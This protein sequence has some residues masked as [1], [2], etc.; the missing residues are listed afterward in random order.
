LVGSHGRAE[1]VGIKLG[2]HPWCFSANEQ[3]LESRVFSFMELLSRVEHQHPVVPLAALEHAGKYKHSTG[4][5]RRLPAP[6]WTGPFIVFLFF[7]FYS[8]SFFFFSFPVFLFRLYFLFF[9]ALKFAHELKK[10][11]RFLKKCLLFLK[12]FTPLKMVHDF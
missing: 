12:I 6:Q 8:L 4:G 5:S 11:S 2:A 1:A 9:H 7:C 10:C 3:Q